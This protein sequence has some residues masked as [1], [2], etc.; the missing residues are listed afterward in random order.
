MTA[1]RSEQESTNTT[2]NAAAA[3][4]AQTAQSL[5]TDDTAAALS[6]A[7]TI[8]AEGTPQKARPNSRART[9][10]PGSAGRATTSKTSRSP[11]ASKIGASSPIIMTSAARRLSV[12]SESS[13]FERSVDNVAT[14]TTGQVAV[15]AAGNPTATMPAT[16]AVDL[17][18]TVPASHAQLVVDN[19]IPAALDASVEAIVKNQD[20]DMIEI[21]SAKA[22][23]PLGMSASANAS[24]DNLTT[25]QLKLSAGSASPMSGTTT[26]GATYATT[27]Q[28]QPSQLSAI[29]TSSEAV[30]ETDENLIVAGDRG[31]ELPADFALDKRIS[32]VSYADLVG[33]EQREAAVAA[34]HARTR[35]RDSLDH[36]MAGSPVLGR[37][38][39]IGPA[40]AGLGLN[41][42]SDN[43]TAA[44]PPSSVQGRVQTPATGGEH[45]S[46]LSRDPETAPAPIPTASASAA[47]IVAANQVD[48]TDAISPAT[49]TSVHSQFVTPA[50]AVMPASSIDAV[51]TP[52]SSIVTS[53]FGSPLLA[54]ALLPIAAA[55]SAVPASA[56]FDLELTR[57]TVSQHLHR[58]N[59][60]LAGIGGSHHADTA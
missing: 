44:S 26:P 23:T 20:L 51:F 58:S 5:Y 21:V 19:Q 1:H 48:E 13:I 30:N 24:R 47:T 42:A 56:P 43:A 33:V 60:L 41:R 27:P 57:S 29:V 52:P 11:A 32:F 38:T 59:L 15:D 3:A 17:V 7:M 25:Q 40:L 16:G 45:L 39:D 9:A 6:M 37:S 14:L 10:T 12:S 55:P 4:D 36:V 28:L 54:A 46:P 53:S 34:A 31:A 22:T 50:K 18:A 8:S 35:S 49:T 2:A